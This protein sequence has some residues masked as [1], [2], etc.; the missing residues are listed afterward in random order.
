MNEQ[1]A[2]PAY[3]IRPFTD[4]LVIGSGAAGMYT[5]LQLVPR[6]VTLVT[7]SPLLTSGST[8]W[9][10]GGMAVAWQAPDSPEAHAADT[11]AAGAGR[12][13]PST[14]AILAQEAPEAVRTL[15]KWNMPFDRDEQ[16]HIALGQEAAHQFRRI[17]HAGGDATGRH[18]SETLAAA[19]DASPSIIQLT[20]TIVWSLETNANGV[21]GAWLFNDFAGWQYQPAGAVVLATGGAGQLY[22]HTTNPP[23][24]TTDGW[25]LAHQAGAL[26]VDLEFVQFHPTVLDVDPAELAERAGDVSPLLTEALRGEGARIL[27]DTG[28]RI[29]AAFPEG[30][31]SPRD[32]VAREV[33]ATLRD[34]HRVYLDVRPVAEKG[35]ATQFQ[36][37]WKLCEAVGLD[38]ATDLLP[39]APMAHYHMGGIQVDTERGRTSVAGLWAVGEVACTGLHGANRLASN[40]LTECL[41]YGHRVA[42]DIRTYLE[43][44]GLVD[45]DYRPSSPEMPQVSEM[46]Q[47]YAAPE[48]PP[49]DWVH[50]ER[51]ASIRTDLRSRMFE[52]MGVVRTPE[53]IADTLSALDRLDAL[54]STVSPYGRV[55]EYTEL[56]SLL[57]S[58]RQMCYAAAARRTSIGSHFITSG[59][60]ETQQESYHA[61]V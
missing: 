51:C 41:V 4:V 46:P 13:N 54:F 2:I 52:G 57:F 47:V 24:A 14:A 36:T 27:D 58:A 15:L 44:E 10:Q 3:S 48:H 11:I 20:Q 32:I 45:E 30:E 19:T 55:C 50:D 61:T 22:A 37:V 6:A 39:I 56:R 18:L 42:K 29:M 8:A 21:V 7:K 1:P 28:R 9:A 40:S 33:F 31:L 59:Q 17:L 49:S 23:T 38:P 16:G 34:G 12:V 53:G 43:T 60:F 26:L 35:L 5:A 25:Y